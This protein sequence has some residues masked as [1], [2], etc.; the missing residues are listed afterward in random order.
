MSSLRLHFL[1]PV[2]FERDAEP[3]ELNVAKAIALL[4]YLAVDRTSRT[5]EQLLGLLWPESSADAAHKNLRN[6]LWALRKALGD[7]VVRGDDERLAIPESVWI[8][9][10][11]F[12]Q[13]VE[14]APSS[15]PTLISASDLYRGPF[16]EGLT[17]DDAPEFEI[18]LTAEQERLGQLYLRALAALVDA[19][20]FEGNW[21]AVIAVASRALAY[22]SLQEPMYRALME[23]HARLGERP[24]ALRQ[25]AALRDTLARELGVEPLPETDALQAAIVGGELQPA[26][27]PLRAAPRTPRRQRIAGET[28][29]VPFVGREAER[30]VLDAEFQ[31]ATGGHAR[32]VLLTGEVGIGKSRLWQEWSAS[33][34]SLP[35]LTVLETRCLE[36][37]QALPFVPLTGLFTSRPCVQRLFSPASPVSPIWMAEIARLVPELRTTLPDLPVPAGLPPEEERRRLFEAFVQFLL[38]L[39][40]HPLVFFIDDLHWAD[41]ATRDWLGYL[42]H[43]LHDHPLLLIAAYRPQDAPAAL[44]HLVAN[45]GREGVARQLP[46]SRLTNEESAALIASLHIDP[47]LA[48]RV[49]AQG[50]GNPYALIELSRAGPGDVPSVLTDLIRARLDRLPEPARQVLQ[51]AAV[52]EPDFDFATLRRTSGRGEEE[53]LDA[54]DALLNA[55]VLIER[56]RD[57]AFAHPLVAAVVADSLSGARRAFLYRRAAEA[58]EATQA[59]RLPQIAGRLAR[60]YTQADNPTRAAY[61][62]ELAAEHALALAAPDEAV[63]FYRQ[64]VA[65]D[66]TPTRHMGLGR[67]L[68]RRGDLPGARAA[69]SAALQGFEARRDHQSAARVCLNLAETYFPAGGFEEAVSWMERSLTY[70]DPSADPAAHALAHLLLGT[71][72]LETGQSLVEAERHLTEAARLATERDVADVATRSHF[73]LGNLYAERGNLASALRAFRDSISCAQAAGDEYQEVL[74]YNNLAYHEVLLGDLAAAREHVE[75]GLALAE[76]RG[77]RLPLQYLYST[78]GEIALAEQQWPEAEDWFNQGLAEAE[79]NGNLQQAANYRA[80][81]GLAARGRGDLDGALMLLEAAHESAA[82]LTAPHLQIKI[83]LWLAELYLERGERAAANEALTR[84]EARLAGG[85]R[86]GL[87]AWAARLRSVI[88]S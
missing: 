38:A 4:A 81:L 9:V 68:L 82:R 41:R 19:R 44:V 62:A 25:Y 55:A 65:L 27:E 79:R 77:L 39:N 13:L 37:T 74:G 40:A 66:P 29:R 32:V 78:R 80:N 35:D 43:R 70:L 11:E 61:Y 53:T 86:Q 85:G 5:R 7:D 2:R 24:E 69:F 15:I 88:L 33:L 47:M 76:T 36:S 8:D 12:E 58:L 28:T 67:A 14:S 72:Q 49:Q 87:Q 23:A 50:A 22:D 21:R 26:T 73:T 18:W 45:W 17:L 46:L 71:S 30:T 75:T 1:G 83:D 51:A 31:V 60:L 57:Y 34:A 10:R 63:G 6:T 64:A 20:R 59:G 54:L 56:D 84:A 48:Q 16:L 52:L 3:V 42:V